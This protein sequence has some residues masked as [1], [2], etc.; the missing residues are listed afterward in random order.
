MPILAIEPDIYPAN[1]LDLHDFNEFPPRDSGVA[2]WVLYTRARQEKSLARDLLCREIRFYLPTVR[3]RLLVRGRAVQSH[4]PLLAGYL[5]V[6][7]CDEDRVRALM[8]NRVAQVLPVQ[9]SQQLYRDLLNIKRLIDS[10]T[11]LTVEAQLQAGQQVRVRSGALQGLEGIVVRR[12]LATRLVVLI[13]MLQQGVS[14][15][16]DDYLLEPID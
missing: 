4:V 13:K 6:H 2:W 5:F 14:L 12:K 15:E 7:C 10:G 9:D 1:L 3:R 11:P 8:T 16:I